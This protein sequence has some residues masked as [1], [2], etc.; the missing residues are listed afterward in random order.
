LSPD[1]DGFIKL[2][3]L[4]NNS[5]NQNLE[6]HDGEILEKMIEGGKRNFDNL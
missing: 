5:S 2:Q 3:E 6:S 4:V 1:E